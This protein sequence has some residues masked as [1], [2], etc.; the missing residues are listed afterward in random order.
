LQR[1][2]EPIDSLIE[3]G[4]VI[5]PGTPEAIGARMNAQRFKERSLWLRAEYVPP[6][7]SCRRS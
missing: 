3:F 4:G 1:V 5:G 6:R 7:L 2:Y